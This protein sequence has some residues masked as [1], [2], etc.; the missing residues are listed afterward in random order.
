MSIKLKPEQEQIIRDEISSG[1]FRTAEE[2]LDHALA[3][4]REESSSSRSNGEKGRRNLA[5]FLMESPL[6]GSGLDLERSKDHGRDI[7]L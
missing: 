5:M 6:A 2:V 4:L 1:R 7:E 3:A